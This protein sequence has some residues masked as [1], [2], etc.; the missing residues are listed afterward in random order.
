MSRSIK[1][2]KFAK[3]DGDEGKSVVAMSVASRSDAPGRRRRPRSVV[4]ASA[5][6]V[7]A[8]ETGD[9]GVKERATDVMTMPQKQSQLGDFELKPLGIDTAC[10]VCLELFSS[11]SGILITPRPLI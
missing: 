11:V 2:A 6:S 3:A 7:A 9:G 4:A 5:V 1:P 8:T 10:K